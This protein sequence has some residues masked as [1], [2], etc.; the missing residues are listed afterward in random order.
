M[1][2]FL[3]SCRTF[4]SGSDRTWVYFFFFLPGRNTGQFIGTLQ[5]TIN[6]FFRNCNTNLLQGSCFVIKQWTITPLLTSSL[7]KWKLY[8][9]T[10]KTN[11]SYAYKDS[12]KS[13]NIRHI[14]THFNHFNTLNSEPFASVKST[15]D[16]LFSIFS[17]FIHK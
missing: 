10:F 4:F 14:Y 5:T 17:F 13:S 1:S 2:T 16:F 12:Y 9:K 7:K 11:L 3:E 6:K 15:C 8:I